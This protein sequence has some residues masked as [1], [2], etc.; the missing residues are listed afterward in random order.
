MNFSLVLVGFIFFLNPCV[1]TVDILP[2]FIGALLVF[3]GI[4]RLSHISEPIEN[5]LGKIWGLFSIGVLR[6]ILSVMYQSFDGSFK[7]LVSFSL[8]VAEAILIPLVISGVISGLEGLKIRYGAEF[9]SPGKEKLYVKYDVSRLRVPLIVYTAVRLFMSV[10]PEFTELDLTGAP[11]GVV[12]DTE[13][14]QMYEFKPLLYG[15]VTFIICI[16]MIFVIVR[17]CK[18]FRLYS[19]DKKMLE[20]IKSKLAAD[21]EEFPRKYA[22]GQLKAVYIFTLIGVILSL[23]FYTDGVNRIPRLLCAAAFQTFF[24]LFSSVKKERLF[25]SISCGATA[26]LSVVYYIASNRFFSEFL[27]EQVGEIAE[28]TLPFVFLCAASVLESAALFFMLFSAS[29]VVFRKANEAFELIGD[30]QRKSDRKRKIKKQIVMLRAAS[31][32]FC[33][34]SALYLPLHISFPFVNFLIVFSEILLAAAAYFIDVR[35]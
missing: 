14:P 4:V 32:L 25:G 2:D 13:L 18:T 21:R 26:A 19:S 16:A 8:S 34:F 23:A 7:L 9:T 28:A 27:E 5:T 31:A 11:G 33:V 22:R 1:Y 3:C 35:L 24:I 6:L 10:L 29:R 12:S 15:F 30:V 17:C 20:D